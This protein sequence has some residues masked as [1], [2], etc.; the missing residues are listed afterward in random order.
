MQALLQDLPQFTLQRHYYCQT[1]CVCIQKHCR[2]LPTLTTCVRLTGA[3]APAWV[4][5]LQDAHNL[6]VGPELEGLV[7]GLG[8]LVLLLED[9]SI[10]S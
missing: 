9:T 4:L 1:M 8:L 5:S 6:L 2:H 3:S 10:S 7:V